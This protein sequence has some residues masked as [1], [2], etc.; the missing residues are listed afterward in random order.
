MLSVSIS[1]RDLF[2]LSRRRKRVI[3]KEETGRRKRRRKMAS[4]RTDPEHICFD[5]MDTL[6][7]VRG[8]V[9]VYSRQ[10]CLWRRRRDRPKERYLLDIRK[11]KLSKVTRRRGLPRL[12]QHRKCYIPF[13]SPFTRQ[14]E[15][16]G[17]HQWF[18]KMIS[19][20][21]SPR[22]FWQWD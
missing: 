6:S 14:R 3:R 12:L 22:D 1:P 8:N 7:R 2:Y 21:L 13:F 19:H 10:P 18:I 5:K 20:L 4:A 17:R 16:E 15:R 9:S 11:Y